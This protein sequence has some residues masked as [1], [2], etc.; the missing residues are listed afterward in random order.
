M[1]TELLAARGEAAWGGC[2]RGGSL[3]GHAGAGVPG[4]GD[5][6][7]RLHRD[8]D[9]RVLISLEPLWTSQST[10]CTYR[11]VPETKLKTDPTRRINPNVEGGS[12]LRSTWRD[13]TGP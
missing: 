12:G 3:G 2:L 10:S 8:G 4:S 6:G 13:T 7:S 9:E 1:E 5:A 11:K